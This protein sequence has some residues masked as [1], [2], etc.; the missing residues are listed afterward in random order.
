MWYFRGNSSHGQLR[1]E[2]S[3]YAGHFWS[4]VNG[5]VANTNSPRPDTPCEMPSIQRCR[6]SPLPDLNELKPAEV[7]Y[8]LAREEASGGMSIPAENSTPPHNRPSC[9]SRPALLLSA[10]T[11]LARQYMERSS[12]PSLPPTRQLCRQ[13]HVETCVW[14]RKKGAFSKKPQHCKSNTSLWFPNAGTRPAAQEE[15][16]FQDGKKH[17]IKF[18]LQLRVLGLA[19]YP[20]GLKARQTASETGAMRLPLCMPPS[21]LPTRG[22]SKS[23]WQLARKQLLMIVLL[24]RAGSHLLT[25]PAALGL[26]WLSQKAGMWAK[27]KR[28]HGPL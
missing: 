10:A 22:G 8:R 21:P 19:V 27:A 26:L 12:T 13:A 23:G 5:G 18:P 16:K 24:G 17:W 9:K 7:K 4:D 2:G 20:F 15:H 6:P 3:S 14:K 1:Q 28:R 11:C 25:P